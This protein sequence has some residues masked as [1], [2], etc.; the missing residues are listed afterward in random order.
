MK[1]KLQAAEMN[2][3]LVSIQDEEEGFGGFMGD[4]Q[5]WLKQ[6]GEDT[7]GFMDKLGSFVNDATSPANAVLA[8]LV[9]FLD[10]NAHMVPALAG[11]LT[12]EG[13]VGIGTSKQLIDAQAKQDEA[14]ASKRGVA[15]S[16][17]HLAEKLALESHKS[18][19]GID[20][21]ASK[22]EKGSDARMAEWAKRT[23]IEHQNKK[24]EAQWNKMLD[25]VHTIET[26]PDGTRR[27]TQMERSEY[28]K[29]R[30]A[31]EMIE[32][33]HPKGSDGGSSGDLEK[34]PGTYKGKDVWEM[35]DKK[36]KHIVRRETRRPGDASGLAQANNKD[37]DRYI[38]PS[39]EKNAKDKEAGK[40]SLASIAQSISNIQSKNIFKQRMAAMGAVKKI[41]G[42]MTDADRKYYSNSAGIMEQVD[43]QMSLWLG[44]QT[45]DNLREGVE[46]TLR[47]LEQI[48]E[49]VTNYAGPKEKAEQAFLDLYH[50]KG[51]MSDKEFRKELYRRYGVDERYSKR[52]P[53][54]KF[55]YEGGHSSGR[56]KQKFEDAKKGWF[57]I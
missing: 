33:W 52:P 13:D 56:E 18:G 36:T 35:R 51:E 21:D 44:N 46:S 54:L 32:E 15:G 14:M 55:T 27:N 26:M 39:M 4:A 8:P 16:D 25:P 10:E 38:K 31:G 49:Y 42:R 12:G 29:R 41:E 3:Q 53:V 23:P 19:L 37:Y 1:Q 57:K 28:T 11:M 43:E 50:K 22:I 48:D 45:P 6:A 24:S 30:R 7:S 40:Q 9:D 5:S 34:V 2:D 47:Q 17:F 20:R